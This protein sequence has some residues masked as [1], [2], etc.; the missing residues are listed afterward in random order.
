MRIGELARECGVSARSIR[1]YDAHG[2][3]SAQRLSNGYRDF[4]TSAIESVTQI[5]MLIAAGF[6]VETIAEVL[7]C[8]NGTQV[9]MCPEVAGLI[10]KTLS[11]IDTEMNELERKRRLV[12]ELLA[13]QR[14]A[15]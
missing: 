11:D 4:P 8:M 9:D 10:R 12:D 3:L 14:V 13:G 2:L 6:T 5:R 15:R 1:H 7:P